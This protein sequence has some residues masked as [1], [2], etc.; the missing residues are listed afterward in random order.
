MNLLQVMKQHQCR[1]IIFSSTA[2]VYNP[3]APVPFSEETPTGNTTNPYATSKYIVENMLRDLALHSG[4]R[5]INLRYFNPIGAHQS[6]LIGE[7]PNDIPNNLLPYVMKVA[8]GELPEL[9][10]F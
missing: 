10:I 4:L 2:S 1:N 5:V 9:R 6:G 7:D 8:N 3:F